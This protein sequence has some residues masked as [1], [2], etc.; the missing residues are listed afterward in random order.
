MIQQANFNGLLDGVEFLIAV[1]S[2]LG[3]LGLLIGIIFLVF[4]GS[5]M[6]KHMIGVIIFSLILITLCGGVDT[7]LKYFHIYR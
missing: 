1:G 5:R 6:R 4:G 2:I 3:L 7:G